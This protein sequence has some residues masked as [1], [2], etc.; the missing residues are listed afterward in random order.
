MLPHQ[1]LPALS[2]ASNNRQE[3]GL[4]QPTNIPPVLAFWLTFLDCLNVALE[5]A[6]TLQVIMEHI[7]TEMLVQDKTA[8]PVALY[9]YN[10]HPWPL[11]M[12]GGL[13][14]VVAKPH[15]EAHRFL[16][17]DLRKHTAPALTQIPPV[18]FL[19]SLMFLSKTIFR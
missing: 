2:H 1:Q 6:E 5:W 14:G 19:I 15:L 12:L 16:T 7:C 8:E 4:E 10:H 17:F 3:V 11:A 9:Y 13:T 18:P